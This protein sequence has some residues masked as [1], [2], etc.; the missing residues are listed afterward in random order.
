[1][2]S[3][4]RKKGGNQRGQLWSPGYKQ[5]CGLWLAPSLRVLLWGSQRQR[6][7]DTRAIYGKGG[8]GGA[9]CL[10]EEAPWRETLRPSPAFRWLQ[11]W[12]TSWFTKNPEPEPPGQETPESD[13]QKLCWICYTAQKL[14][15][16][17]LELDSLLT[18]KTKQK[19]LFKRITCFVQKC[20]C[21]VNNK[22]TLRTQISFLY[23]N[24][25]VILSLI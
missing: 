19:K 25:H 20:F 23:F 24:F 2:T 1:M 9:G 16:Q 10:V 22:D 6:Q 17:L 7:E 11:P 14:T 21:S 5:H 18:L 15:D 4:F 12:S 3:F 8:W 13:Q